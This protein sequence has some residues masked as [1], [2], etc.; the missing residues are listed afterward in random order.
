MA[1]DPELLAL[2]SYLTKLKDTLDRI[3]VGSPHLVEVPSQD[4][5]KRAAWGYATVAAA[6]SLA[7]PF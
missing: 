1:T 3:I 4:G 6:A 7:L 2:R 5:C